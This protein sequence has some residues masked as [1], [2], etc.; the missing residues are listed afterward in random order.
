VESQDSRADRFVRIV[1]RGDF[2]KHAAP[3][4]ACHWDADRHQETLAHAAN[5]GAHEPLDPKLLELYR[6]ATPTQELAVVARLNATLIGLKEADLRARH[7]GVSLE[8]SG[9]CC[10][11]GG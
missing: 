3:P 7:P 11:A 6:R 4:S 5:A 10:A 1:P 9:R 2:G 8:N